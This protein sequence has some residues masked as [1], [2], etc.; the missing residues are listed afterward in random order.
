MPDPGDEL[1][2]ILADTRA[3]LGRIR[4]EMPE[5]EDGTASAREV[6]E[7]ARISL[8]PAVVEPVRPSPPPPPPVELPSVSLAAEPSAPAATATTAPPAALE[9]STP[10]APKPP[11][12]R[13]P[14]LEPTARPPSPIS[15][16]PFQPA[17]AAAASSRLKK[18][19]GP[20]AAIASLALLA[21]A[22]FKPGSGGQE[23]PFP[24]YDALAVDASGAV[25]AARGA[26]IERK[27]S[28][29]STL[30]VA[31]VDR[32]LRSLSWTQEGLYASDG[33][34]ALMRWLSPDEPPDRFVLDHAPQFVFASGGNVWTQDASGN[35]RQFLLNRSMTGVYL[36]PLDMAALPGGSVG[37]FIVDAAGSVLALDAQGTLLRF[38]HLES[39]FTAPSRGRSYGQGAR[40]VPAAGGARVLIPRADGAPRLAPL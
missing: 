32:P 40:L 19:A 25:I 11:P 27:A 36:Q 23:L 8:G 16:R 17:Q 9:P 35:I 29:G 2:R 24:D 37:D 30:R 3:Q 33:T 20:V 21:W 15:V 10:P 34:P 26:F 39:V 31:S 12:A 13:K 1:E 28:D 22:I 7:W 4:L 18:A 5:L 14:V 6:Q 38:E